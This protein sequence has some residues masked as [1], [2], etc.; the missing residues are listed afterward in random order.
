MR[1]TP[2]DP[3]GR[4]LEIFRGLA[5]GLPP[6]N[7]PLADDLITRS[8]AAALLEA[9]GHL[10]A[11][12]KTEIDML[13]ARRFQP[14]QPLVEWC[15]GSRRRGGQNAAPARKHQARAGAAGGVSPGARSA[16]GRW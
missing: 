13:S 10:H 1:P 7:K 12:F 15:G 2:G 8:K 11:A 5:V 14:R 6:L 9:R 16:V 3:R 4:A